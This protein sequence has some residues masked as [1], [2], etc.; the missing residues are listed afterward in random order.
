[1]SSSES[2]VDEVISNTLRVQ[3]WP[4]FI[5]QSRIKQALEISIRAAQQR[6]DVMEHTLL[7][8]PPG[9]GK[10]TLANLI[11]KSM[12][13]NIRVTSGPALERAGDLASLLSNLEKG[14]V[15]FIDEIHR[16]NKAVEETLYPAMEDYCLDVVLGKGPGARSLRLDLNKFTLV[17]ATTR[18]GLLSAPLRDR[19]GVTHRLSFYEPNE[20]QQIILNASEKLGF[21]LD[22]ASALTIALR[23]RLT[24]RIALKL[25]RRVRDFVQVKNKGQVTPQLTSQALDLLTIDE[26]GLDEADRKLLLAIIHKHDGGPVGVETLAALTNDDVGTIQD[27]YEPFLLRIGF[28]KRTPRGRM[29]TPS[30]YHH[31]H[32]E[33]PQNQTI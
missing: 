26:R 10:T 29:V 13:V 17:G 7:Y 14:D 31:L 27:V 20:L 4:E 8:G 21:K 2:P 23:S 28:L 9:L 11:A 25:L 24:A 15:L 1:M 30:A 22:D 16:L 33:P 3:T 12:G 32:L 19:F 5:G 6:Q 18:V